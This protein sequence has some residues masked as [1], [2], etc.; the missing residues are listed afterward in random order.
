VVLTLGLVTS[1][2]SLFDRQS[3][4]SPVGM[5]LRSSTGTACFAIIALFP[6][7]GQDARLV[8]AADLLGSSESDQLLTL[9]LLEN[10]VTPL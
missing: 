9:T 2:A 8:D 6:Q 5:P 1:Q 7:L 4:H 3:C 10:L